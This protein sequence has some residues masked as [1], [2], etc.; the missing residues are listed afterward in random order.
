MSTLDAV[1]QLLQQ[2]NRAE[3]AQLLQWVVRDLGDAFPG[4]E[5]NPGVCGGEPCIVRTRIPV[6]LLV[7]A[8]R[9]GAS[10]ADLLHSYSALRAE[11]LANAWSYYRTHHA[12]I[13][14]Q[15]IENEAA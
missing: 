12:A 15:I 1:A 8:R 6:W 5:S 9:L 14:A 3:K 7:Q 10:E 13:D 4:I 2:M 11:D